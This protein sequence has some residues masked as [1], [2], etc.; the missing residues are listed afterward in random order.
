M[1]ISPNELWERLC[2]NTCEELQHMI[3]KQ[4]R[5]LTRTCHPDKF[6]T[7]S[8]NTQY[9]MNRELR[10]INAA[11]AWMHVLLVWFQNPHI[12]LE[13]KRRQYFWVVGSYLQQFG[14]Q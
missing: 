8:P 1:T 7:S 6:Q 9:R 5:E 12:P 2:S 10:T 14:Q 11:T 3:D 13:E 4:R